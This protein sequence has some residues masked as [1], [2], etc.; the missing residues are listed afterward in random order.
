MPLSCYAG[1]SKELDDRNAGT[2][3]N[4]LRLYTVSFQIES[5]PTQ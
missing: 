2:R 5:F 1:L 4:L 3:R